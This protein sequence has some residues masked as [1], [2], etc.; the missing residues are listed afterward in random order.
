MDKLIKDV[1]IFDEM[2]LRVI[3]NFYEAL[4][5]GK[6]SGD[7]GYGDRWEDELETTVGKIYIIRYYY[8]ARGYDYNSVIVTSE[9]EFD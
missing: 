3:H 5:L 7:L 4:R 9:Y 6:T 8:D 1:V 2:E